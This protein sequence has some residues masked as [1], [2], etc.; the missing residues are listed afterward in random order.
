MLESEHTFKTSSSV[1]RI[2][3]SKMG[4]YNGKLELLED[5]NSRNH[6]GEST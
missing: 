5:G 2:L 4:A 1:P 6:C 3:N